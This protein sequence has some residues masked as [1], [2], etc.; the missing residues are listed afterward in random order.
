MTV[1]TR[2]ITRDSQRT[3]WTAGAGRKPN[4]SSM[5][6]KKQRSQAQIKQTE[7]ITLQRTQLHSGSPR[8]VLADNI[9][10]I[11]WLA[12]QAHEKSERRIRNGRRRELYA[13]QNAG[14]A[15]AEVKALK[16]Q[17]MELTATLETGQQHA[18]RTAEVLKE[19]NTGMKKMVR[20]LRDRLSR[21][22]SKLERAIQKGIQACGQAS[23]NTG[24]R[25]IKSAAGVVEDWA[26]D[27]IRT[28]VIKVGV[29]VMKVPAAF[30]LVARALGVDVED[31]VSDRT[32]RRMVLEGGVLAKTWLAHEISEST[33]E[34]YQSN[35]HA[36]RA[37]APP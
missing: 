23:V 11:N 36:P 26:R 30:L 9:R 27:L 6:R 1:E 37:Y 12:K 18:E 24:V 10:R 7:S 16:A 2:N 21:V 35:E 3:N 20:R 4:L 19:K 17:V 8:I 29:P 34:S 31:T 32:C 13:V 28:L 15:I 33:S 5:G 22:P 14:L 25:R